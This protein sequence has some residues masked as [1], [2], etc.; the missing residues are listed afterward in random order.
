MKW[1]IV[2]K[3]QMNDHLKYSFRI[4]KQSLKKS[5]DSQTINAINLKQ[6]LN[7]VY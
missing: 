3:D 7:A 1:L 4:K 2:T 5:L 6:E